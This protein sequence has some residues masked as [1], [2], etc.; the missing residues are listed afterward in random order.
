MREQVDFIQ[1]NLTNFSAILRPEAQAKLEQRNDRRGAY[2]SIKIEK[3]FVPEKRSSFSD[4][5]RL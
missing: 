3:S 5:Y 2:S 1:T 4:I